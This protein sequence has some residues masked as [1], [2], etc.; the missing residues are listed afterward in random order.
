MII[1][2]KVQTRASFERVEEVGLDEYKVWTTAAPADNQA[3]EALIDILS[4]FFDVSPSKIRIRS[5]HKS[6]HKLIEIE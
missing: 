1:K 3:N 5:G 2:V 4:D 6:R